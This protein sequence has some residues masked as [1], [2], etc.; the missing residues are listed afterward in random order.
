MKKEEKRNEAWTDILGG[1]YSVIDIK[2]SI[3]RA[4]YPGVDARFPSVVKSLRI[5]QL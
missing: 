2:L 3:L 4:K 5:V 1:S